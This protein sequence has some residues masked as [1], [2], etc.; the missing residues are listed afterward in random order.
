MRPA[1]GYGQG[2]R[3]TYHGQLR[4]GLLPLIAQG[5]SEEDMTVQA[6][7]LVHISRH[8]VSPRQRQ[9]KVG[10]SRNGVRRMLMK[11]PQC[12]LGIVLL[13]ARDWRS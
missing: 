6:G 5:E 13:D 12:R 11:Y 7:R 3:G 10:V 4:F 8:L 1:L 2:R 9:L